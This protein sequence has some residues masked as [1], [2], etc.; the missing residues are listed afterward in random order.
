MGMKAKPGRTT[1]APRRR[2]VRYAVAGLGYIA[3]GAVLPAFQHARE[4]CELVALISDDPEK[5]RVLGRK[6]R[7]K[8]QFGYDDFEAGLRAAAVDAVY[9]ALP[10][11]L[12]REYTVRAAAAGVHVLCEKPM[13]VTEADCEEMIRACDQAGVKLMIAYRLH[14]DEANMR[15]V[16]LLASGR[17]GEARLCSSVF[18]MQVKEGDIRLNPREQGGG[19]LYD[20]GIY[21]INAARYLF[22]DEPVEVMA[23]SADSGERRFAEPGVEE[24]TSA[25]LRFADDRLA[26]FTCSFGAAD[27]S[28]LQ[29]VGTLG[30]LVM[31]PAFEYAKPLSHRITVGGR[32]TTRRFPKR[33]QFAPELV[34][35]SDCVMSGED[36]GPSGWE[37]LADVRVIRALHASADSGRAVSLGPFGRSSRPDLSQEMRKPPVEKPEMVKAES[38]SE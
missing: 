25:V 18:T 26:S 23:R 4:N 36:P 24:M 14:F 10:N 22:R 7:V 28:R 3:Q 1:R 34:H 21:C 33:D 37:G 15:A 32:T 12:H 29:V 19:T 31:D 6:Y 11:H 16:D 5:L 30:D 9:L 20:I 8:H 2:R 17:L 27:V 38:P 13:A 35:F